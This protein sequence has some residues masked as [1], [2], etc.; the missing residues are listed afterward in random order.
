MQLEVDLPQQSPMPGCR[1]SCGQCHLWS[2][3][4]GKVNPTVE[5]SHVDVVLLSLFSETSL[6]LLA[7]SHTADCSVSFS[8]PVPF[9]YVS[10][11]RLSG[12]T[13]PSSSSVLST[14]LGMYL[15]FS[16]AYIW[17]LSPGKITYIHNW[18]N[19]NCQNQIKHLSNCAPKVIIE[20]FLWN[21]KRD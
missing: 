15:S 17:C 20:I 5:E 14:N 10:P 8:P 9:P 16:V 3:C 11:Q 12:C 1:R 6:G 19:H 18:T 13:C 2:T 7:M 4:A 21:K